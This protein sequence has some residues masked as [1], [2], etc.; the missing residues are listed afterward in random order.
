MTREELYKIIPHREPMLLLD[1]A[2]AA[3]DGTAHGIYTVKGDEW[4]LQG[5]FPGNP[6]VPGVIQCEM[7]AQTCCV[8]ISGESEGKNPLFS[9]LDKV[10]FRA[11]VKPGD[12]LHFECIITKKRAPFFFAHAT[13]RIENGSPCL[14]ADFSFAL[15]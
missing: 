4:F 13:G 1:E 2:W 14:S 10:R 8:L 6:I 3:E 7:A 12:T 9:G 5:H 15:M 11:Q